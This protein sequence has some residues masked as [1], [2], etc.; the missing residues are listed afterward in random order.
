M[1]VQVLLR[2]GMLSSIT[3]GLP[4]IQGAAVKGMQGCGVNTPRW[5]AVAAATFGLARLKHIPKGLM[6]S[7]GIWSMMLPAGIFE[8]V[9]LCSGRKVKGDGATPKLQWAMPVLTT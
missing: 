5:D 1:Q 4:G 7:I 6:F 3:V 9:S 2:V 8:D